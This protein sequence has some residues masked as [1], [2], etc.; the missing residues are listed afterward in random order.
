MRRE[1]NIQAE[2]SYVYNS[3]KDRISPGNEYAEEKRKILNKYDFLKSEDEALEKAKTFIKNGS[4][5]CQVWVNIEKDEEFYHFA[6]KWIV[7]DDYKILM[8]AEYLG[9]AQ[10]YD[11][12]QLH[13]ILENNK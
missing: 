8:A 10:V 2:L 9:F 5:K 12:T 11:N 7:S 3:A 6:D 1:C 4:F 13:I